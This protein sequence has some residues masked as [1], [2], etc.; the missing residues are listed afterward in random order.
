MPLQAEL[1]SFL[2]ALVF[3]AKLSCCCVC[4]LFDA[5]QGMGS[6]KFAGRCSVHCK[7]ST[8]SPQTSL[9]ANVLAVELIQT[10]NPQTSSTA[11]LAA[12]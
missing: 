5:K 1:R 6:K 8:V 9:S 4:H 11:G 10:L 3:A 7:S 12:Y 2:V